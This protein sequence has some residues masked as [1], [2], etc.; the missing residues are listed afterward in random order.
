MSMGCARQRPGRGG[1]YH[2]S[3]EKG[4]LARRLL[5]L[6]LAATAL[7]SLPAMAQ[8]VPDAG[9]LQRQ[10]R[11]GIP[12]F[13]LE[14]QRPP[15][16]Q[17]QVR[18]QEQGPRVLVRGFILD[19]A[20]LIP[21]AELQSLLR[22][23]VGQ[24]LN[25]ND[26]QRLTLTISEAYRQRGYFARVYL[27]AQDASEGIVRI[28]IVEGRF[29]KVIQQPGPNRA[30]S[31]FVT[32]VASSRLRPGAP[33]SLDDLERGLLLANDL[34]GVSV[35]GILKA[36]DET[37]TS[38]LAL[39]IRDTPLLSAFAN[40]DNGGSRA[41]GRYR[42]T[43][44][45][46][47]NGLT[48]YGDRLSLLGLASEGLNYGQVGLDFPLG[49]DGLRAS[50]S[51]T[52]LNYDLVGAFKALDA[53]G[54]AITQRADLSYPILRAE[55]HTLRTRLAYEHSRYDDDALG[56]ALHRKSLDKGTISLEG[57]RSDGWGG[58]G[59]LRYSFAMTAGKLDLSGLAVD[60]A[61]DV[62]TART[63]GPFAKLYGEL[64]RDQAV[65]RALFLRALL[66]G[67]WSR[68]NLDSSEQFSLGGP[69]GVRAYPV[70][71]ASGDS[72]LLANLELHYPVAAGWAQGLDLFGFVDAGLVR[73]HAVPWT[74]WNAR[75]NDTNSYPLFGAGVGAGYVMGN[76]LGLRLVAA[77]PFGANK[78]APSGFNQDGSKS[79]PR[80]W[81]SASVQF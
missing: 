49:V 70:N 1:R 7:T 56:Q 73:R 74:G 22:E 26:L 64:Q 14:Q 43:A 50:L 38:D 6:A 40:G 41:S 24:E 34:P 30:D 75:S 5:G 19:G 27:P 33:Y 55:R 79:D 62:A 46:S 4:H 68:R 78:G 20:A 12:E 80:I 61:F 51:L 13:R 57:N 25:I 45:L 39:E 18:P 31:D 54:T 60:A 16:S 69:A 17:P 81:F 59:M 42:G 35:D 2:Q 37:G 71:E 77:A 21:E 11:E 67:Q 32:G 10:L 63:D 66:A 29:G 47:L 8:V 48:G 52:G 53:E 44:G 76:G 28:R 36:G 15:L 58:G 65:G 72:G 3:K 23:K 9:S